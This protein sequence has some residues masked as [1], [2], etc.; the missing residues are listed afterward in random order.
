MTMQQGSNE[1]LLARCGRITA[2]RADMLMARTKSGPSASRANLL[3]LLAVERITGQPVE[4]Y[5]NDAMRRGTEIEPIARVAYEMRFG[6]LVEEVGLIIHPEMPYVACS[7]DGLLGD[8]GMLEI[9]A[10]SAMAK[11]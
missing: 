6:T 4:T 5:Q 3:A 11:H 9:K 7:P 10:P 8:D 1:W 2:S